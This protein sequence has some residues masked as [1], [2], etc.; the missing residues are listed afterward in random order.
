MKF[1]ELPG[2]K[3]SIRVT[4]RIGTRIRDHFE[5]GG[6]VLP[7][8]RVEISTVPNTFDLHLVDRVVSVETS[9]IADGQKLIDELGF[10][11]SMLAQISSFANDGSVA[12]ETCFFS[13]RLLDMGTIEIGVD[14]YVERRAQEILGRRIHD[15][16]EWLRE[17]SVFDLGGKSYIFLTGGPALIEI[18]E[19]S[20]GEFDNEVDVGPAS[21]SQFSLTG[22]D[23]RFVAT[24]RQVPMGASVWVATRMTTRRRDSDRAIRL[25][26]ATVKFADWTAVGA[27]QEIARQQNVI[28]NDAADSYLRKWDEFGSFEG[29]IFLEQVR[30][31]GI[32]DFKNAVVGKDG[33]IAIQVESISEAAEEMIKSRTVTNLE[34]L[35]FI[36]QHISDHSLS[37]DDFSHNLMR[38]DQAEGVVSGSSREMFEIVSFDRETRTMLLKGEAIA[39]VGQ[40]AMSTIGDTTQMKRRKYAR[41]RIYE[42]RA[43]NPYLGALIQPGGEVFALRS[44]TRVPPLTSFVRKKVFRNPPTLM[45]E[46]AIDV[47]LNTPDIALIQGPPGTG[48]TTVIAAILERLNERSVKT[49]SKATGTVL[50]SAFQQDAVENMIDR[51]SLNGIPVPKFGRKSGSNEDDIT[52]FERNLASWCQN[53]S[54]QVRVKYPAVA[55]VEDEIL[56]NDL[57]LQY[58]KSPSRQLV[59]NMARRISDLSVEVVGPDVLARSARIAE[60]L[61][62]HSTS[63]SD[64]ERKLSAVRQLRI[65]SE[66]FA[67]DGPEMAEKAITSLEDDLSDEDIDLLDRASRWTGQGKQ[68]SF[69]KQLSTLKAKLLTELTAPPEFRVEKFNDD[70]IELVELAIEKLRERSFKSDDKMTRIMAEFLSDLESNQTG[71]IDAISEY[72]FA[73]AATVQQSVNKE[74][75][76]RK[77]VSG[78][79]ASLSLEYDYVIVDEAARV[80]PLDL[81]IPMS[82]GKKIILVGDHRQL[83]H[84]IDDEVARRMETAEVDL[85][86]VEWLKKSLF[87]Y[88][89]AE[90]LKTLEESDGIQRRVTLDVQFRMHPVLGSFVSRNFY[91]RFDPDEKFT[92]GLNESDFQHHLSETNGEH[93]LWMD[94]PLSAGVAERSGTSW[95][96]PAEV[97]AIVAQLIKWL[98]SPESAGLTFGV[99]SFY[100][101]QAEEIRKTLRSNLGPDENQLHRVRIGT[102]DSFQ[103]ME[104]DVVFLSVVRT[105]P[106]NFIAEASTRESQALR[107]FGHLGLYNRL[108]V[109]M[110]RQKKLLVV[111]G[112]KSLFETDLAQEFVPGLADFLKIAHMVSYPIGELP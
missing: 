89:F 10:G 109:S 83:P 26:T 39:E 64:R 95:K 5:F 32:I 45:Q 16:E 90:R 68:P 42:G 44:V 38:A 3:L 58:L 84:V 62:V 14:E 56:L 50:L 53:I 59:W 22:S 2:S 35:D 98:R 78:R 30:R 37:F 18:L 41:D 103:G 17:Q 81:M 107:T 29:E 63:D 52:A 88:M 93:A 11:R 75:Q 61:E 31:F 55:E 108:N 106:S 1:S 79:D 101:S 7:V 94:V 67:D 87:Q 36:P 70:V 57:F 60:R 43:A 97:N 19:E 74:M 34:L 21:V 25:A 48:K 77:G 27:I 46:R 24:E 91:E 4:E 100:Q 86:E 92:S 12:L 15:V 49:G 85:D 76:R 51:I 72:S 9:T 105:T 73:F 104:F 54:D 102:V 8:R 20:Q 99:I 112:E 40:L 65:H 33:K 110:S 71:M 111:A 47:A 66:S 82:Q 13:G 80:S 96:R 23:I 28:L 6:D 69:L